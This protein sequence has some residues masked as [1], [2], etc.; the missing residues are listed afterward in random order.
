MLAQIGDANIS[1]SQN[2]DMARRAIVYRARIRRLA[3]RVPR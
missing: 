1:L 3:G 2:K